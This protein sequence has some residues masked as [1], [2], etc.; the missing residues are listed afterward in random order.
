MSIKS[1]DKSANC[2]MLRYWSLYTVLKLK[3]CPVVVES[4]F[5][6]RFR[7]SILLLK[8][9]LTNTTLRIRPSRMP[10]LITILALFTNNSIPLIVNLYTSYCF[11]FKSKLQWNTFRIQKTGSIEHCNKMTL[12]LISTCPQDLL[13]GMLLFHRN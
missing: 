11:C 10:F 3:A 9:C 1:I 6:C 4:M 5:L 2:F 8:L 13:K 12:I 7:W